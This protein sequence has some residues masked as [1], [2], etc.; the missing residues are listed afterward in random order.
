VSEPPRFPRRRFGE[1]VGAGSY[2]TVLVTAALAVID[3]D[4]VSTGL[5][6]ELV[7]GVGLATWLAHLYA[8]VVGD[9]L[10]HSAAPGG[11]EIARAMVD[12]VPILLAAVLP[13]VMLFLGRIDVLDEQ[14]ALWAAIGVAVLQLVGVGVFVGSAVSPRGRIAWGYAVATAVVGVAVVTI[15]FAL[16]H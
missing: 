12:G 7:T 5:G 8:E 14:A 4:E 2:G 15:E 1:W 6:W 11:K 13:A 3:A 9:H 16:G 10:R